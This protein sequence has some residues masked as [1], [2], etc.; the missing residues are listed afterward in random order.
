MTDR[1]RVVI[2]DDHPLYREGVRRA[3]AMSGTIEVVGEASN[4]REALKMIK[5][6][7]P[8]VALVD[9]RMPDMDG[10]AL[11]RAV[12]QW[13]LATRVVV[14][15]A[16]QNSEL[17]FRALEEGAAGYLLKDAKR[18]ELVEA[19]RQA[20]VGRTVIPPDLAGGVAEEIRM[21]AQSG[22]PVFTERELEVLR[23]FAE[24]MSIPQIAQK[25]FLAPSTI[26][27]HAQH[28]YEKLGVGDRAAAVAEGM[29]RG[30]MD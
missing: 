17:V 25:L 21:R 28:L 11:T 12:A 18:A 26:K 1:I 16:F 15:S 13:K 9:F 2:A 8:D 29:R 24:G 3:L 19:V 4:G 20:A 5:E 27:T 22:G 7:T 30:L 10:I 23:D 6:L 14:V